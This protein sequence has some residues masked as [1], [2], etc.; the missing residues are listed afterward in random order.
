VSRLAPPLAFFLT[1]GPL[2]GGIGGYLLGRHRDPDVATTDL[3][4][5][6]PVTPT[7]TVRARQRLH[8][9]PA[10][11]VPVHDTVLSA[12]IETRLLSLGVEEG[13]AVQSGALLGALDIRDMEAEL[14]AK[15]AALEGARARLEKAQVAL[16][17][18]EKSLARLRR[19]GDIVPAEETET[20]EFARRQAAASTQVER[21]EL[22]RLEAE[23][24][25]VRI[26]ID[27]AG[28]TASH[29]GVVA[30]VYARVGERLDSG[31][32]ILRIVGSERRV[33]LAFEPELGE[34][35][36][37]GAELR[38]VANGSDASWPVRVM[39]VSEDVDAATRLV[40]AEAEFV[41]R[42]AQGLLP[43]RLGQVFV[44]LA[45]GAG[46]LA[47]RPPADDDAT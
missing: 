11:V 36:T 43:G 24:E 23:V 12:R 33:R 29:D 17:S 25:R 41:D 3:P 4:I 39:K 9:L 34:L 16:G 45:D 42:A 13:S 18:A 21:H 44:P 47:S 6:T 8:A 38:F 46:A 10:V 37:P 20:A 26:A 22:E 19:L 5:A 32:R 40:F 35:I 27:E 7:P 28:L 31:N 15:S 2:L 1:L 30:S 14:A